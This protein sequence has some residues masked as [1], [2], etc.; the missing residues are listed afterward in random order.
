[1]INKGKK[2]VF[3]LAKKKDHACDAHRPGRLQIGL[4]RKKLVQISWIPLCS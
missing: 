3:K 2:I 4:R 1:M